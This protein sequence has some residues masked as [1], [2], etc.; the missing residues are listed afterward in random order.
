MKTAVIVALCA[1][2]SVMPVYALESNPPPQ[3]TGENF[4]QKKAG[5]LQH[6]DKRIASSQE[7]KVCV[8]SAQSHNELKACRD[9]YRPKP[10]DDR[11]NK[12]P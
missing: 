8:Q 6:I 1:G 5:I 4:Q 12:M 11:Q 10:H 9:K 7:E 3:G 2:M